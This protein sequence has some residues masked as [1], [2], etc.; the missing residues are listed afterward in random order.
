MERRRE[1]QA[2]RR[3]Q[4]IRNA[5]ANIVGINAA[6]G[7]GGAL[8]LWVDCANGKTYWTQQPKGETNWN[9]GKAGVQVAGLTL[10]AA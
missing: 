10:F 9:G 1:R 4:T 2:G 6:L 7:S 3:D 8:H 5:E